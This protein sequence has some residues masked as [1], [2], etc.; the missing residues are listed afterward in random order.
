MSQSQTVDAAASVH[1]KI[2][3]PRGETSPVTSGRFTV[4][5]M[6]ASMSRSRYMLNAAA[7]PALIDPPSTVA[8]TSQ[9]SGKPP[10]ARI[11]TGTVVTSSS[12]STRGFVSAT[13]ARIVR[14]S[15]CGRAARA[16]DAAPAVI[17]V[18]ITP[19][20]HVLD[21]SKLPS[22][23]MASAESAAPP[24][25]RSQCAAAAVCAHRTPATTRRRHEVVGRSCQTPVIRRIGSRH[26]AY[27]IAIAE[28]RFGMLKQHARPA[29]AA[30]PDCDAVC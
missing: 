24:H 11:I 22:E 17:V 15:E 29:P 3:A 23:S 21:R 30:P 9:M 4:R 18:S 2:S 6:C 5:C 20:L 26:T 28:S 10:C 27:R 1:A 13:Y 14:P 8:R 25:A 19:R 12:S 16:A 7:D